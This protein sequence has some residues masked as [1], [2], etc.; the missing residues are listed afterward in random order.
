MPTVWDPA[1]RDDLLRR[2]RTLTPQHTA[3][4]GKFSVAGMLA[5]LN[6]SSRMATGD[7]P[8]TSKAPSM[9]KWPPLRYLIIH[10][11]PMPK[12]APTAP[13]LLARSA[14]A[15]LVRELALFE[16]TFS[17]LDGRSHALVP[18]PAFGALSH[19]DWGV[20]IHKHVD[21]HLRQFGV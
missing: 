8:V 15:E 11:L 9:L 12:S 6:E 13:E 14:S 7:L 3:K 16:Q 10:H 4:W 20:L 19:A 2:A 17:R 1:V 21:H 5:H 18:H